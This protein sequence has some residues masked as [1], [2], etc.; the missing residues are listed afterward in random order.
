MIVY[1][2]VCPNIYLDVMYTVIYSMI[3]IMIA[4]YFGGL[5][6]EE[7]ANCQ[8]SFR[9]TW[10]SQSKQRSNHEIYRYVYRP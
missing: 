5:F 1:W 7:I 2:F 4:V 8:M 3:M 9:P 6:R 10:C